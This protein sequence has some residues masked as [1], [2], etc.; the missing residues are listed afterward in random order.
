[1]TL[2]GEISEKLRM[3]IHIN[4][5]YFVYFQKWSKIQSLISKKGKEGLKRKVANID[6]KKV[7][8]GNVTQAESM[9]SK[10]TLESVQIASSGAATFYQWVSML[11]RL[12]PK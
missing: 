9:L 3:Q 1:M 12:R 10:Y 2:G 8:H 7:K 11:G 4:V 5:I 6:M